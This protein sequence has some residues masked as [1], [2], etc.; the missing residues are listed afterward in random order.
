MCPLFYFKYFFIKKNKIETKNSNYFSNFDLIIVK[1]KA[2]TKLYN[3]TANFSESY[4]T[5]SS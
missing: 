2:S 3:K 5:Q 4:I 1:K